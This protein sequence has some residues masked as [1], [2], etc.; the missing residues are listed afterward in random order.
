MRAIRMPIAEVQSIYLQSCV[1]YQAHNGGCCWL[2]RTACGDAVKWLWRWGRIWSYTEQLFLLTWLMFVTF[3]LLWPLGVPPPRLLGI[4]SVSLLSWS[5]TQQYQ[6][7]VRLPVLTSISP[8]VWCTVIHSRLGHHLASLPQRRVLVSTAI[9]CNHN[10]LLLQSL[11]P[12][13]TSL[14]SAGRTTDICS[15]V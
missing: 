6:P 9:S 3:G 13:V 2:G 14:M 12:P 7:S 11:L 4:S 8:S 5:D 15:S 10:T 1:E